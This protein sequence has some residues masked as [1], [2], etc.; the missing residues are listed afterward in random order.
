MKQICNR[1]K[2]SC[3]NFWENVRFI[4]SLDMRVNDDPFTL[5]GGKSRKETAKMLQRATAE[6]TGTLPGG[7]HGYGCQCWSCLSQREP[8]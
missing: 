3:K 8:K 5:I 2:Y 4:L 1:I 6:L 7:K